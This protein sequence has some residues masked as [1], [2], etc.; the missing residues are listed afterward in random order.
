MEGEEEDLKKRFV[1]Y[2][3]A[4]TAPVSV[5]RDQCSWF[6]GNSVILDIEL[7]LLV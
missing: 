1:P 6:S 3:N 4:Q 2:S 7:K 5:L